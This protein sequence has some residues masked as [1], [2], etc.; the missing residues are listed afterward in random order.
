MKKYFMKMKH[1]ISLVFLMSFLCLPL[2]VQAEN[3]DMNAQI[4]ENE[5]P[6]IQTASDDYSYSN[7]ELQLIEEAKNVESKDEQKNIVIGVIDTGISQTLIDFYGDR[8]LDGYN[9]SNPDEGVID[10]LGHGSMISEKLLLGTSSS[11][12][13]PIKCVGTT[14]IAEITSLENAVQYAIDQNVDIIQMALVTLKSKNTET[15]ES[16]ILKAKEEGIEVVVSAGNAGYDTKYYAPACLEEVYVIGAAYQNG[17]RREVSNY[18]ESVDYNFVANDTSSAS[19]Y[20][21]VLLADALAKEKD[22]EEQLAVYEKDEAFLFYGN[23]KKEDI[24]DE[25]YDKTSEYIQTE[26]VIEENKEELIEGENLY[27][28]QDV[29]FCGSGDDSWTTMVT[30]K[31]KR[32]QY[33]GWTSVTR[34]ATSGVTLAHYVGVPTAGVGGRTC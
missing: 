11:S 10:E 19:A 9:A 30:V 28:Y 29:W 23:I 6:E 31:Y 13:L 33:G 12:V 20:F 22:L 3:N 18:G 16:L 27:N 15:L 26:S 4:K 32:S 5:V 7:E 17:K 2:N 24:K 8:V 34:I 1:G 25:D 21:T 14:G